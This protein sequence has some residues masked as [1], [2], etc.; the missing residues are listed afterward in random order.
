MVYIEMVL[1]TIKQMFKLWKMSIRLK[2][3][4][5]NIYGQFNRSPENTIK[6]R[7]QRSGAVED[8]IAEN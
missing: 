4:K 8:Q 3:E 7:I 5:E 1:Y 2:I 6:Q